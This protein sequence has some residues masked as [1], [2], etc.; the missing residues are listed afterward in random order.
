[1]TGSPLTGR[2]GRVVLS[3]H[4]VVCVGP[5]LCHTK[6]RAG[7]RV[8]GRGPPTSLKDV[9]KVRYWHGVRADSWAASL[10]DRILMVR[11]GTARAV[12]YPELVCD[13][14]RVLSTVRAHKTAKQ[15]R[16]LSELGQL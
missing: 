14:K 6:L 5:N 13:D 3:S 7:N 15:M 9:S 1:M 4:G 11:G 16:S 12:P 8:R 2:A 10:I